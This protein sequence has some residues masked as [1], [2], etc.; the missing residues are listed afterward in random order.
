MKNLN[1]L[2]REITLREGKKKNLTIA[3]VKE[4]IRIMM[5]MIDENGPVVW[6]AKSRRTIKIGATVIISRKNE[7][8]DLLVKK[9]RK[10]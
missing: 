9:R 6:D 8:L 5:D 7:V 2:A 3:D 10:R 4:V 1:D